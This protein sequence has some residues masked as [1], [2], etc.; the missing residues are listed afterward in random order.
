VRLAPEQKLVGDA[1]AETDVDVVF[2][3]TEDVVAVVEPQEL[4]A[5]TV[6]IPAFEVVTANADGFWPVDI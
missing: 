3:V 1:L 4:V 6:Y 2:T 5:D